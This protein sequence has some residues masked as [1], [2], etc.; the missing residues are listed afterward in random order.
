M[1]FLEGKMLRAFQKQFYECVLT[2]TNKFV[3]SGY[4]KWEE[5]ISLANYSLSFSSFTPLLGFLQKAES[6]KRIV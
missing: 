3:P 5:I 2:K 1:F 4:L 6:S